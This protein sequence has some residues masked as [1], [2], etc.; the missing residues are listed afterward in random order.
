MKLFKIVC[1]V[2]IAAAIGCK[3]DKKATR[4][5]NQ[6]KEGISITDTLQFKLNS[7]N[8]WLANSETHQ[9]VKQM[10]AI[11]SRFDQSNHTDYQELGISLS[12]QTSYI[13]KNCTMTGESHDQLHVVLLP[14][15]DQISILRESDN[16][17][18]SKNAL[19]ELKALITAYYEHFKS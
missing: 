13:I 15:L 16:V 18:V 2:L 19:R 8:K 4:Q 17:A 11:I 10:E 3:Q 1:I 7:G 14:M 12:K 9:G 5:S 6:P